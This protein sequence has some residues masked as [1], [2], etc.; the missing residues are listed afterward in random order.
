M[1]QSRNVTVD[2]HDEEGDDQFHASIRKH[3]ECRSQ[4]PNTFLRNALS[5]VSHTLTLKMMATIVEKDRR[6]VG[7]DV[8]ALTTTPL[9]PLIWLP[10][11]SRFPGTSA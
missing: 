7:A 4:P 11:T 6:T 1:R 9:L 3:P 2:A 10:P 8:C 5:N